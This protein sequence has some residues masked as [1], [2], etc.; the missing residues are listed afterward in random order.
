MSR[1]ID[2]RSLNFE[3]LID[4][5][6]DVIAEETEDVQDL[7]FGM[8]NMG[9]NKTIAAELADAIKRHDHIAEHHGFFILKSIAG[10][11]DFYEACGLYV[12]KFYTGDGSDIFA[13]GE[14]SGAI[15]AGMEQIDRGEAGAWVEERQDLLRVVILR[16]K[17]E[18]RKEVLAAAVKVFVEKEPRALNT[19][20][21]HIFHLRNPRR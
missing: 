12:N 1:A 10:R 3:N 13:L 4:A 19:F 20:E 2:T 16:L 8:N 14:F 7:I 5:I 15:R 11:N 17:R 6:L 9:E 18:A 21:T